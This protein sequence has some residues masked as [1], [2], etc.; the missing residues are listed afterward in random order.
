[1]TARANKYDYSV[2]SGE[3]VP[4][5]KVINS[6]ESMKLRKKTTSFLINRVFIEKENNIPTG[7]LVEFKLRTPESDTY[8]ARGFTEWAND[9]SLEDESTG[10]AVKLVEL[11]KLTGQDSETEEVAAEE[12]AEDG[13]GAADVQPREE[14]KEVQKD[15][16]DDKEVK[17][18][19]MSFIPEP[20]AISELL[21]SLIGASPS[22]KEAEE[23]DI[24]RETLSA[25]ASFV[26]DDG[27]V[28]ILWVCDYRSV[29]YIG[30]AL[31][32]I[33]SETAQSNITAKK[34]PDNVMENFHEVLNIGASLFN[35]PELPHISLGEVVMST[36]DIPENIAVL[37]SNP[38]GRVDYTVDF[39]DYGEG[40][41]SILEQ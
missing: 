16:E 39:P 14:E 31:A 13:G 21:E 34:I 37:V 35:D 30:S 40:S 15:N 5:I 24:S 9:G 8:L 28:K 29:I 6:A 7:S 18:P 4:V 11:Y 33:P 26:L 41:M 23:M 1:M 19:G 20:S 10:V 27:S 12:Q 38:A 3:H 32:A 2:I 22:L 36:D 17:E 25:L